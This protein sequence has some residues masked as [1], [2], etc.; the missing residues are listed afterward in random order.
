[1]GEHTHDLLSSIK[2]SYEKGTTDEFIQ[3]HVLIDSSG[4]P[5]GQIM[6]GDTVIFFNFRTDRPRQLTEALS[7]TMFPEHDMQPV[8]VH[9]ITMTSYDDRYKDVTVLFPDVDI[10][11]T[12]GEYLQQ[13]GKTQLRVAETEK[14]PHVSYFF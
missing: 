9:M 10:T 6:D 1:M 13:L 14:Y 12:L 3:P 4:I 8:S 11:S 2:A 7:Q 5:F